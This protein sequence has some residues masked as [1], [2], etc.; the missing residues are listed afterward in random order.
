[1]AKINKSIIIADKTMYIL[2]SYNKYVNFPIIKIGKNKMN[3]TSVT[4]FL[5]IHLD[6]P[7]IG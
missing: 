3:E 4:K 2:F 5:D 6:P 7:K 1:M